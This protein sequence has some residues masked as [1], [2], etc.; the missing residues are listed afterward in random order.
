MSSPTLRTG[1]RVPSLTVIANVQKR[2]DEIPVFLQSLDDIAHGSRMPTWFQLPDQHTDWDP[3]VDGLARLRVQS[4]RMNSPLEVVLTT[5]AQDMKPVG[6]G[7]AAL[8]A[9]ERIVRL[10]MDWQKHRWELSSFRP[11]MQ[12]EEGRETVA[13]AEAELADDGIGGNTDAGVIRG[14]TRMSHFPIVS[15]A[16]DQDGEPR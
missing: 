11:P 13:Q 4:L 7:I 2:L 9:V 12:I 16:R 3:R 5:V 10:V 8:L 14:V 6:Y 1:T 15:V